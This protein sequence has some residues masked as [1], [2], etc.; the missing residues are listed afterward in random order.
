MINKMWWGAISLASLGLAASGWILVGDGVNSTSI[1]PPSVQAAVSSKAD[2][3]PAKDTAQPPVKLVRAVDT[4]SVRPARPEAVSR[5]DGVVSAEAEA[6][7]EVEQRERAAVVLRRA[8][9]SDTGPAGPAEAC[10]Q[11][12]K[13]VFCPFI[14][15]MPFVR[16]VAAQMAMWGN[17]DCPV[18]VAA[19]TI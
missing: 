16:D 18:S 11:K 6:T 12:V 5:R 1:V 19:P 10:F 7:T 17:F 14:A 3:R 8:T 15:N 4:E 2:S 9:L 13:T